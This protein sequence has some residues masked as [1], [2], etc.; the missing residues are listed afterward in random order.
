MRRLP[1]M[2]RASPAT[3]TVSSAAAAAVAMRVIAVATAPATVPGGMTRALTQPGTLT[4]VPPVARHASR[5]VSELLGFDADLLG[6]LPPASAGAAGLECCRPHD[7]TPLGAGLEHVVIGTPD[8]AQCLDRLGDRCR[9]DL[10]PTTHDSSLHVQFLSFPACSAEVPA[11]EPVVEWSADHRK[12]PAAMTTPDAL[13][14]VGQAV[15]SLREAHARLDQA[16]AEARA[17]GA[18][19]SQI[20]DATGMSRQSAHERWGHLPRAGCQRPGC[21]C[22]EHLPKDCRCGHGPG[23]GRRRRARSTPDLPTD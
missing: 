1:S 13:V 23:R 20:G 9:W 2:V 21:G 15:R 18:T 22:S 14:T 17:S 8:C 6:E 5:E 12:E 10:M 19:W 11:M 7:A 3:A 16:V 4:P